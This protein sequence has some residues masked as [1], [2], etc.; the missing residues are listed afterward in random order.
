MKGDVPKK[1][2][3]FCNINLKIEIKINVLEFRVFFLNCG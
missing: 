2:L 3:N 1:T